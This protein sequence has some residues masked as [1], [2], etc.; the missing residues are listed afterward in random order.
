MKR[1]ESQQVV[2]FPGKMS[3]FA[4]PVLS[5]SKGATQPMALRK[6]QEKGLALIKCSN[7]RLD[8]FTTEVY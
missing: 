2:F 1:S 7:A 8:F 6:C 4:R 5:L 3:G